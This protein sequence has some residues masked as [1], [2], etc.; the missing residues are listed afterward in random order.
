[1]IETIEF[2]LIPGNKHHVC[3]VLPLLDMPIPSIRRAAD[4][5]CDRQMPVPIWLHH[6][7]VHKNSMQI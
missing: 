7:M 2:E 4:N 6:E 5:T 1:M 3:E